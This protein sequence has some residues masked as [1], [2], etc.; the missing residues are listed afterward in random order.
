MSYVRKVAYFSAVTVNRALSPKVD[1]AMN[2]LAKDA[3]FDHEKFHALRDQAFCELI[4]HSYENVPYYHRVMD[5]YGITPNSV[6]SLADLF[7]FP[8]LTKKIVR[9]V[10][11]EL[12]A[13]NIPDSACTFRRS[14]GTTGEPI[15]SY[16]DEFAHA[17][18]TYS[19]FRGMEWMGW[20][21]GTTI[22]RLFGGSLGIHHNFN[23]RA[24]IE[25]FVLGHVLLPAFELKPD[26][27]H[28]YLDVIRRSKDCI[29]VGYSSALYLLALYS[30]RA[31]ISTRDLSV[32]AIFPTSVHLED[33]WLLK[34]QEVFDCPVTG[35]YG[36]AEINSLGFQLKTGGPYIIPDEHVAIEVVNST[37]GY[38]VDMPENSLLLTSLYNKA[39]PWIRY[40]NGDLGEVALPG[41]LHP[42][43]SCLRRL[44]GRSSDMFVAHDG[45]LVPGNLGSKTIMETRVPV[46]RYQFI[47]KERD[48]I[49]FRYEA[50]DVINPDQLNRVTDILRNHLGAGL[51]VES[52]NTCD[53]VISQS[54][55]FR[56][57]ISWLVQ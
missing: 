12:R 47:Q 38:G 31:K 41:E 2:I 53:F 7:R 42:V 6:H 23:L 44:I 52:N 22:I 29:I 56:T 18:E 40:Q 25:D 11:K 21:P 36:C 33:A 19:Y 54:G 35:Y 30:Q 28:E 24:R 1:L 48:R 39:Q 32:R 50:D 14:G 13:T 37:L 10:G 57:V 15:F 45:T 9:A 26:N 46:L 5:E 43:R 3:H 17:L 51:I 27:V 49:E 4:R 34:I 8:V 16:I 55:K 20:K